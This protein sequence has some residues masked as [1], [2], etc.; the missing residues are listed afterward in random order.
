[1]SEKDAKI[2]FLQLVYKW[3]TFGS[4]FFEVKVGYVTR[5]MY[6]FSCVCCSKRVELLFKAE[7]SKCNL[8]SGRMS[9]Q[10]IRTF[11]CL[12]LFIYL[13]LFCCIFGFQSLASVFSAM[14]LLVGWQEGRPACKKFCSNTPQRFSFVTFGGP[15][16]IWSAVENWTIIMTEITW[17]V[18][19]KLKLVLVAAVVVVVAAAISAGPIM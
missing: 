2:N 15:N 12:F 1:M 18:K 7:Y 8:S 6:L 14:L 17:Q 10:M 16:P 4:A 11:S 13:S 3:Q 5:R 19:R 9:L